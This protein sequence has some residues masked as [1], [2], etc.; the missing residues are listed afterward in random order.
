[1]RKK[2]QQLAAKQAAYYLNQ[3]ADC[4]VRQKELA[5]SIGPAAGKFVEG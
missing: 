2:D 3:L 1:M 4:L 5:R